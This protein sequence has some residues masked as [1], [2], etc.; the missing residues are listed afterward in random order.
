MQGSRKYSSIVDDDACL[1]RRN[2]S[3]VSWSDLASMDPTYL[4]HSNATADWA[5]RAPSGAGLAASESWRRVG[6]CS[7]QGSC[8]RKPTSS[9]GG[10]CSCTWGFTGASCSS[11]APGFHAKQVCST[12]KT[13][14]GHSAAQLVGA[15]TA[16]VPNATVG[17]VW[18]VWLRSVRVPGIASTTVA[19]L[20]AAD[21]MCTGGGGPSHLDITCSGTSTQSTTP[22]STANCSAVAQ[23]L[24]ATACALPSPSLALGAPWWWHGAGAHSTDGHTTN[25]VNGNGVCTASDNSGVC[26]AGLVDAVT[27]AVT[28]PSGFSACKGDPVFARG[29]SQHSVQTCVPCGGSR[30]VAVADAAAQTA[31]TASSAASV[32]AAGVCSGHGTCLA[33]E[34]GVWP[35]QTP[36]D[37]ISSSHLGSTPA[38]RALF[39]AIKVTEDKLFAQTSALNLTVDNAT[40]HLRSAASALFAQAAVAA[41]PQGSGALSWGV[42]AGSSAAVPYSASLVHAS[43]GSTNLVRDY[44]APMSLQWVAPFVNSDAVVGGGHC[45]CA[46]GWA[47]PDCGIHVASSAQ[48]DTAVVM[49]GGASAALA[50]NSTDAAA[51]DAFVP[52]VA[53]AACAGDSTCSGH[54]VCRHRR[55]Y[56][57]YRLFTTLPAKVGS[58]GIESAF[59]TFLNPD[60][61]FWPSSILQCTCVAGWGG[62]RCH[63]PLTPSAVSDGAVNTPLSA[64]VLQGGRAVSRWEADPVWA[65]CSAQC[66]SGS[67][68]R[69]TACHARATSVLHQGTT[70]ALCE[71]TL[72][73]G[74]TR[75]SDVS[76][77]S[78]LLAEVYATA[79][80][81]G[82]PPQLLPPAAAV[83]G[84]CSRFVRP[85]ISRT[86]RSTACGTSVASLT[87]PLSSVSQATL[88]AVLLRAGRLAG[89]SGSLVLSAQQRFGAQYSFHRVTG[90]A[91]AGISAAV[92]VWDDGAVAEA[93][94]TAVAVDVAAALGISVTRIQVVAVNDRNIDNQATAPAS[95]CG[96]LGAQGTCAAGINVQ[97][98][99]VNGRA[100]GEPSST[101][102][103]ETLAQAAQSAESAFRAGVQALFA[104]AASVRDRTPATASA[105]R[106]LRSLQSAGADSAGIPRISASAGQVDEA[107]VAADDFGSTSTST[108]GITGESNDPE[109]TF[110]VWEIVGMLIAVLVGMMIL[111]CCMYYCWLYSVRSDPKNKGKYRAIKARAEREKKLVAADKAKAAKEKSAASNKETASDTPP[112]ALGSSTAGGS[113]GGPPGGA[114]TLGRRGRPPLAP[115]GD[116]ASVASQHSPSPLLRDLGDSSH[117]VMPADAFAPSVLAATAAPARSD[118]AADVMT[119]ALLTPSASTDKVAG[120]QAA[121]RAVQPLKQQPAS[122]EDQ[123]QENALF[124]LSPDSPLRAKGRATPEAA[125]HSVLLGGSPHSHGEDTQHHRTGAGER[126]PLSPGDD[127]P[128]MVASMFESLAPDGAD[129]GAVGHAADDS[130]D[131]DEDVEQEHDAGE[132]APGAEK[133]ASVEDAALSVGSDDQA[134]LLTQ[135]S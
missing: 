5:K 38:A 94:V 97:L 36:E 48:V 46:A 70:A 114:R 90:G 80:A 45:V 101:D 6:T 133:Q 40:S 8:L 62:D 59:N 134:A 22:I 78:D 84:S 61:P 63:V 119:N 135:H 98:E 34:G 120:G 81:A 127:G 117:E 126:A 12:C 106:R 123:H 130:D 49:Q 128:D 131:S 41:V 18:A 44:A 111:G 2:A 125:T 75:G 88:D 74:P 67:T 92:H 31:A 35:P 27:G 110:T 16:S 79:A 85:S 102:A 26:S 25:S 99:V 112:N 73:E 19:R 89:Q 42:A 107:A 47:G 54:G 109:S 96:S 122:D 24:A 20:P 50:L 1:A 93:F 58:I 43:R 108:E 64:S 11:C 86:C 56:Q 129:A 39:E 37:L 52:L 104:V 87:L 32:Y 65:Q 116:S 14:L 82:A 60:S 55:E 71:S 72:Y 21:A 91:S 103:L 132:Y 30:L 13:T 68:F 53:L 33:A 17:A 15:A 29:S 95:T 76:T 10:A 9:T 121:E 69:S 66:N 105:R 51:V 28:C 4:Y 57:Q 115:A 118:A 77:S 3:L 83:N 124:S 100:A 23:V 7:G 113:D